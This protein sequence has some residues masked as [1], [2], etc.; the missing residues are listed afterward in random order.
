MAMILLRANDGSAPQFLV[1]G[2]PGPGV[3]EATPS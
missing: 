3:W 2:V 1:P